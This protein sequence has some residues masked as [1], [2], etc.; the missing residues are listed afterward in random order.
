MRLCLSVDGFVLFELVLLEHA[1]AEE[2]A[3]GDVH[4]LSTGHTIGYRAEPGWGAADRAGHDA[5]GH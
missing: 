3:P 4:D 1:A 2:P 5:V